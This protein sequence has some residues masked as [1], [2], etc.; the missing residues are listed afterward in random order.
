VL[1]EAEKGPEKFFVSVDVSVLEPG[2]MAAAGRL[3]AN[4][5]S[6]Q[7]LSRTIRTV[8]AA[9]EIVGFEITDMAPV[10]DLSRLSVANANTVL[11]A[12][13]VGMAVRKA[14]LKPD[15]VHPLAADHG[16]K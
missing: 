5:L 16:Q 6:I 14:G 11:N 8:C 3:T 12:C 10:L 7:Q 15:Y 9:K 2:D 13:L 1:N 4:G